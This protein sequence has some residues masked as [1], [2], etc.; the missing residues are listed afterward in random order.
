MQPLPHQYHV[1]ASAHA[2]EYIQVSEPQLQ[3]ISVA[4]PA[5]FDGPGD[6]WSPEHL[7]MSSVAS[8]LISTFKAIATISKL[9]WSDISCDTTG[10]LDRVERKMQFTEIHNRVSLTISDEANRE[11]AEKLLHKAEEN[12]LVANTLS[13]Q[14]HLSVDITIA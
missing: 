13:A 4:P 6:Q 10:T 14:Q 9:E 3:P 11:K 5:D 8:C 12:C 2:D 1:G 7:L